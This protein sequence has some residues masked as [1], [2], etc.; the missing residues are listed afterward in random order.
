MQI[1]HTLKGKLPKGIENIGFSPSGKVLVAVAIDDDHSIAA[2][3][4][5]SGAC[6]GT[7]KGDKAKIIE[8]AMKSD[9]EFATAGVKHFMVWTISGGNLLSK[10]G[11]FGQYDQRIGSVKFNKEQALSGCFTGE[12]FIWNGGSIAKAVKGHDRPLDAIFVH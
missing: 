3:D 2:Y 4:V 8:I 6:L 5:E 1:K 12:L 10:R 9:T 11:N 7:N